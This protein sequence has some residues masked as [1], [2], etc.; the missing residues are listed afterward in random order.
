MKD[1]L[2]FIFGFSIGLMARY[3]YE[4]FHTRV[5]DKTGGTLDPSM[6]A[7]LAFTK[8]KDKKLKEMKP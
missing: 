4:R 2:I 5:G 1:A 3:L 8:P 7:F 6:R